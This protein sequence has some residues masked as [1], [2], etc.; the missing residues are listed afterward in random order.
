MSTHSFVTNNHELIF[1]LHSVED[2]EQ[3]HQDH[4]AWPEGKEAQ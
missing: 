2:G 3:V 1:T 4:S